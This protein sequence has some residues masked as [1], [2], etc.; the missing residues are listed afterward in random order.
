MYVL[1]VPYKI[2]TLLNS[3]KTT[4]IYFQ[5]L[6]PGNI[7]YIKKV[8]WLESPSLKTEWRDVSILLA[9]KWLKRCLKISR[10]KT[11]TFEF[12]SDIGQKY[13]LSNVTLVLCM[14]KATCPYLKNNW[15]MSIV[16][17]QFV[18]RVPWG[19]GCLGHLVQ[20]LDQWPVK[21]QFQLRVGLEW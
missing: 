3:K 21:G 13:W 1:S 17:W 19:W 9:C 2:K 12:N 10:S 18:L 20:T 15:R 4:L 6:V 8:I 11:F 5:H 7:Y 14:I 16:V